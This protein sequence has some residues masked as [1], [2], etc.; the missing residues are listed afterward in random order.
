MFSNRPLIFR[1]YYIGVTRRYE[2]RKR[3]RDYKKIKRKAE[4]NMKKIV[5]IILTLTLI[6]ALAVTA[7]AADLTANDAKA[8]ALADAGFNEAEVIYIKAEP[9]MENGV[10]V[11][12]VEFLVAEGNLYREYD[13]EIKAADGSIIRKYSEIDDDYRP[14]TA[15]PPVATEVKI[16]RDRAIELAAEA[17]GFKAGDI[18]VLKAEL[19][20]DD[21]YVHYDIEFTIDFEADYDCEVNAETGEVYDK[22]VDGVIDAG[23][24]IE[25]FFAYI[26]A[27]LVSLFSGK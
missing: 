3:I 4:K 7:F 5:S 25:M 6:A 20:R 16:S 8:K 17:F 27:W 22:D 18:K 12:D 2:K 26:I 9:D 10:K 11:F 13:Y 21:G 1:R 23:D 19:D 15:N 24:K 14:G